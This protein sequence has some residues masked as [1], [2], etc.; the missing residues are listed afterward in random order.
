MSDYD[1]DV[2]AELQ[3]PADALDVIAVGQAGFVACGTEG[4]YA[5]IVGAASLMLGHRLPMP[6]REGAYPYADGLKLTQETQ[7]QPFTFVSCGG[8]IEVC[9]ITSIYPPR[10]ER[11]GRLVLAGNE[12][13]F[14][15]EQLPDGRVLVCRGKQLILARIVNPNPKQQGE[16]KIK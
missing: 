13:T 16:V 10:I 3:M 1:L 15:V 12:G 7:H 6:P 14:A 8:V 9:H 2:L 4:I 11:V 5:V